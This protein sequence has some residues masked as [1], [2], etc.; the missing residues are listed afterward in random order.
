MIR[1]LFTV[2]GRLLTEPVSV[3]GRYRHHPFLPVYIADITNGSQ[4]FSRK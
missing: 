4:Y 2:L 3:R 1:R